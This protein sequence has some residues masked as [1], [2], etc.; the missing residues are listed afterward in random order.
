MARS[1]SAMSIITYTPKGKPWSWTIGNHETFNG[2]EQISSSRFL[3]FME[4]AAFDDAF[5]NTRRIGMSGGLVNKAGD[6][7][8]N[9]GLFAAHSIDDKL[10]NE[11]WIAAM[12]GTYSPLM[13]S[14]Q[15]HFG[16]NYQHRKFQANN[17]TIVATSS[18]QPSVNQLARYRARPFSQLTDIRF[19]DTTNFA[20]KSD[21]IFGLEFGAHLTSR[22]TLPPKAS[23][24]T[25]TPTARATASAAATRSTSSRRRRC[26]SPAATRTSGAAISKPATSSPAK[27]AATRTA[28]GTGPR[29]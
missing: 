21:D 22:C 16:A 15:L 26:W 11:G 12:R 2:L 18:G 24:C 8:F 23:I 28:R 17:G 1:A 6:L 29:C 4:R 3:S 20:A 5:I 13:G 10:D 19:V 7:R 9:A 14:T 25:P 27:L